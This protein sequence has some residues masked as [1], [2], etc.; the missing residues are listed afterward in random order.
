M[1]RSAPSEKGRTLLTAV[2]RGLLAVS[3]VYA[4]WLP[5]KTTFLEND[6]WWMLPVLKASTQGKSFAELLAYLLGPWPMSFGQPVLKVYLYLVTGIFT[7]TAKPLI[8]VILLLHGVNAVLLYGVYRF[9]DLSRRIA[10]IA[11]ALHAVAFAHFHALFFLS[12]FRHVFAM[13]SMLLLLLG[14]LGTERRMPA[15]KPLKLG[16]YWATL[17]LALLVSIQREAM[18]VVPVILAHLLL[19]PATRPERVARYRRWIPLFAVW[20]LYP[21]FMV[22]FVG[23]IILNESVARIACPP[24]LKWAALL[25]LGAAALAGID[26]LIRRIGTGSG[27]RK[28][29]ALIGGICGLALWVLLVSHDKRQLLLP[30]NALI[31]FGTA[32]TILLDPLTALFRMDSTHTLH[33][34]PAWLPVWSFLFSGL[35]LRVFWIAYLRRQPQLWIW[36]V[37]Y[38][39]ALTHLLRHYSN[40]PPSVPSR[41]FYYVT[42]VLAVVL[43]CAVCRLFAWMATHLHIKEGSLELLGAALLLAVALPNLMAIPLAQWRGRM[44]NTYF[45]YDDLRSARLIRDDLE[46]SGTLSR[47]GTEG[48]A[49]H[50]VVPMPT[51]EL[52]PGHSPVDPG[53]YEN[54]RL[55]AGQIFEGVSVPRIRVNE[56]SPEAAAGR[57]L[58]RIDGQRV[59]GGQGRSVNPF[60]QRMAEGFERLDAGDR[61]EA[62]SS[63]RRAL[64]KRPVLFRYLLGDLKLSDL[65]WLTGGE[66][67]RDWTRRFPDRY[68]WT[69]DRTPKLERTRRVVEEEIWEQITGLFLVSYLLEEQ[70]RSGEARRW[71][72]Q[73]RFLESDAAVL[74]AQLAQR[75]EI[76]GRRQILE[77]LDR[78]R[79]PSYFQEPIPWYK[80]DFGFERFLLRFM[81]GWNVLSGWERGSA[82]A[83]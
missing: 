52:V 45:T 49:V 33:Y 41:Y 64:E 68:F 73:I 25:A 81:T 59:L 23:D 38:G 54:F 26:F 22:A 62:L 79:E 13:F 75:P 63:F 70:G 12:H 8:A 19:V 71:M 53:R 35:L 18:I 27:S 46:A 37:W 57:P 1:I 10:F 36:A 61:E 55:A 11:A 3:C 77:H 9:L 58:Y 4:F 42:P 78:F 60:D 66:T 48:V 40:T 31:P 20:M 80:D 69:Q 17:G 82:M 14:Y 29:W 16:T 28:R 32:V 83:L 50:G 51:Q 39:A 44:A 65:R 72:A 43:S 15:E 34:F 21:A 30:Y 56:E 6:S 47:L 24:A 5:W 74:T 2:L 7:A 76:R 67:L